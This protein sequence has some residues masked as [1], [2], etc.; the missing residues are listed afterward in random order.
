MTNALAQRKAE[1]NKPARKKEWAPHIWEGCDFLSWMRLLIRNRFAV[2]WRYWYVAVIITIISFLHTILRF[3][4]QAVY[5]S[6]LARTQA[7]TE[8]RQGSG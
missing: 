4:Q 1:Q 5:G 6:R 3:V 7:G 8:S 2:N